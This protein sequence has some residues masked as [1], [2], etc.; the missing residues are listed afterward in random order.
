MNHKFIRGIWHECDPK[1]H[2]EI[3]ISGTDETHQGTVDL[4]IGALALSGIGPVQ[5]YT[6][7]NASGRGMTTYLHFDV[8]PV[9]ARDNGDMLP[10]GNHI[11]EDDLPF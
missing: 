2:I 6:S 1:H 10:G 5:E 8:T 4:I 11:T 3:T 7:Q 9:T